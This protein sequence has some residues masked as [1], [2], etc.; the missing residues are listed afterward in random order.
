[1]LYARKK[2][3]CA[4][5]FPQNLKWQNNRYEHFWGSGVGWGGVGWG[6]VGWGGVSKFEQATPFGAYRHMPIN[7]RCNILTKHTSQLPYK[8]WLN[9][10]VAM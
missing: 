4:G 2:I 9:D 7:S 3:H 5:S 6:G 8:S 1:M 10:E